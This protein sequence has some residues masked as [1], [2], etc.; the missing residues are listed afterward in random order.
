MSSP[1]ES[2]NQ[3]RNNS[4]NSSENKPK[5]DAERALDLKARIHELAAG[6]DLEY[7][8]KR[9]AIAEEFKI[10]VAVLDAA[11]TEQRAKT[12]A[13][14]PGQA[15]D[16]LAP[17]PPEPWPDEVDGCALLDEIHKFIGRF[18][19]V[20][21]HVQVAVTLWVVFSYLLDVA[22]YSTRLTIISATMRC[23]KSLMLSILALLV[24][25]P[26]PFSNISPAAVFRTIELEHPALLIDEVDTMSLK[27]GKSERAEELRGIVN[28]GHTPTNAFVI[29]TEKV[30]DAHVPR[31]FST[32][33]P[34][35]MA[36]IRGLPRTWEDRSIEIRM[37]RKPKGREV[38]KLSPRRNRKAFE[39]AKELS[40][41]TARW[42]NDHRDKLAEALPKLPDI[43]DRA[44]NNWELPLAIAEECGGEWP[45]RGRTAAEALS[46][47]RSESADVGEQLLADIRQ[48]FRDL[49]E[50]RIASADLCNALH[51]LGMGQWK[52]YGRQ[53]KPI[54]QIQVANLLRPFGILPGT[55][56]LPDGRS[57]RGYKLEQFKETFASYPDPTETP[58]DSADDHRSA[59]SIHRNAGTTGAVSQNDD[60]QSTGEPF[61]D[62]SKNGSSPHG[63]KGSG[64]SADRNHESGVESMKTGSDDP[65]DGAADD[66]EDGE[67]R[68]PPGNASEQSGYA[69]SANGMPF[70]I[71]EWMKRCLRHLRYDG[72]QMARMTPEKA[73]EIINARLQ[74]LGLHD[75]EIDR[76]S[77]DEK[78]AAIFA[79]GE[80]FG[81]DVN[82]NLDEY[83]ISKS[84]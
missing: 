28:S 53:Q 24:R 30:G 36:G 3:P 17:P 67:L 31:K 66:P 33:T 48:I 12:Q 35:A 58:A 29:R 55:I 34:I 74:D 76:M 73:H 11:V 72:Q 64:I 22:D 2:G 54:T 70:K 44:Q 51:A 45:K 1:N 59:D 50:D 37:K 14:R 60:F 63:E 75:I 42:A 10:R 27:S 46:E 62:V 84:K 16:S 8:L 20:G 21:S 82:D 56:D 57:L 26:L 23:G 71:M 32:W 7:E 13:Q 15:S 41:K 79:G 78:E 47:G 49:G 52:E 43:D 81:A 68:D 77:P 61:A 25:R 65:P 6:N 39:Q 40:R 38:E 5:T 69:P 19:V 4:A 83:G 9:E 18:V 80:R